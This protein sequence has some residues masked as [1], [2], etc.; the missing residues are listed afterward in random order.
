MLH[1]VIGDPR[2]LSGAAPGP[3]HAHRAPSPAAV[4]R[5]TGP[6]RG[7]ARAR[8]SLAVAPGDVAA[9]GDCPAPRILGR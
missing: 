2:Q 9:G 8:R 7:G 1:R 6:I 3:G 5:I 4:P